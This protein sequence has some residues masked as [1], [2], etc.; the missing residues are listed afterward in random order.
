M[1]GIPDCNDTETSIY[2]NATTYRILAEFTWHQCACPR[3]CTGLSFSISQDANWM[4]S[5]K[6]SFLRILLIFQDATIDIISEY[7]AYTM[8]SLLCDIG[9]IL[10]L[11]LGICILT[12]I[13]IIEV[14]FYFLKNKIKNENK[15]RKNVIK[16]SAISN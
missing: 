8:M 10:G 15:T 9:S 14:A 16:V 2:S 11:M 1:L 3:L 7:Y 4:Y 5:A 12:F 13:Q 6:I